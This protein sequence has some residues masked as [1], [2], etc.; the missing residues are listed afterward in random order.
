MASMLTVENDAEVPLLDPGAGMGTLFAATVEMLCKR[1]NPPKKVL[2]TAYEIE[3]LFSEYLGP[4]DRFLV[5]WRWILN[6]AFS[7]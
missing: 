2:V 1:K 4:N 5:G 3:P 7:C 6:G